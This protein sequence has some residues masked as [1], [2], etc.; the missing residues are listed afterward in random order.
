MTPQ[1]FF[2]MLNTA[3][4]N[5]QKDGDRHYYL[6]GPYEGSW[7]HDQSGDTL[8]LYIN[9]DGHDYGVVVRGFR[10]RYFQYEWSRDHWPP[11][12]QVVAKLRLY[13]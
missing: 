12:P 4:A 7:Y 6:I 3:S 2:T 8:T 11:P 13:A 10:T 5:M 1:E 9:V